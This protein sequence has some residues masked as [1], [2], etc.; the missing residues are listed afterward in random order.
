[1]TKTPEIKD[2]EQFALMLKMMIG[3]RTFNQISDITGIPPI[4]I[5][6][7]TRLAF[8]DSMTVRELEAMISNSTIDLGEEL[9]AKLKDAAGY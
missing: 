8:D 6:R 3:D 4:R 5:S 1:M 2:K 9:L 7:F